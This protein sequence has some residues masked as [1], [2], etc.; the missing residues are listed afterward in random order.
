M[1]YGAETARVEGAA[2]PLDDFLSGRLF[3]EDGRDAFLHLRQPLLMVYGTVADRRM[4]TYTE[5]PELAGREPTW[6]WSGCPPGRCRTGSG[7]AR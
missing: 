7:R 3:P 6:R 5:L 4:E 2:R 1:E